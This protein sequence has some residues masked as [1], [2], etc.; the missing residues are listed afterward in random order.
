MKFEY[1]KPDLEELD[2]ELEGS[3]LAS[4]SKPDVP[5]GIDEVG[6]EEGDPIGG[7]EWD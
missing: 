6:K 2:L 7:D 1:E 5:P 3:F 4:G